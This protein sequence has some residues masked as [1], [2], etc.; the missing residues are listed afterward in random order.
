M[1]WR[2]VAESIGRSDGS[3]SIG[4]RVRV[5]GPNGSLEEWGVQR[6]TLIAKTESDIE[7]DGQPRNHSMPPGHMSA[8]RLRDHLDQQCAG[9]CYR[10]I[11]C[12]VGLRIAISHGRSGNGAL[13]S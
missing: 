3:G 8:S 12:M 13:P 7:S 4:R 2:I 9:C 1:D 11:G 6:D 5:A 10:F